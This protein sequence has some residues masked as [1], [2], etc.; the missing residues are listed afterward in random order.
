MTFK[1]L[2][3]K[4]RTSV[5]TL[6]NLIDVLSTAFDNIE[7]GSGGGVTVTKIA[8]YDGSEIGYQADTEVTVSDDISNYD[9]L[10]FTI[11]YNATEGFMNSILCVN[12]LKN[13]YTTRA[14]AFHDTG[15]GYTD[16]V[17]VSETKLKVLRASGAYI[18]DI[19]GIKI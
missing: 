13:V 12:D 11:R 10:M 7:G 1:E 19:Y 15:V 14:Y 6:P 2:A 9:F 5:Q 8:S 17:Y 16:L 18:H 4:L 3:S